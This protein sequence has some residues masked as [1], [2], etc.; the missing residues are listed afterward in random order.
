M[1]AI[2]THN[3]ITGLT[4]DAAAQSLT[5]SLD[6]MECSA[7]DTPLNGAQGELVFDLLDIGDDMEWYLGLRRHTF[8]K[9]ANETD[10]GLK[11]DYV[12]HY[13]STKGD[14]CYYQW[15]MDSSNYLQQTE[16]NYWEA[17]PRVDFTEKYSWDENPDGYRYLRF[18]LDNQAVVVDN[19]T[20]VTLT[21]SSKAVGYSNYALF[22]SVAIMEKDKKV[23][24]TKFN[25]VPNYDVTQVKN[26]DDG[27]EISDTSVPKVAFKSR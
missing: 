19:S 7:I 22:P 16:L 11:F 24:I 18:Q 20:W 27:T 26:M 21:N 3:G 2:Q 13:D 14:L 12:V 5:N 4:F 15:E 8:P 23:V 25:G 9:Y 17:G 10:F 1:R 6:N